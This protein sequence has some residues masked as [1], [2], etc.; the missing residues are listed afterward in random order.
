MHYLQG[1]KST[2]IVK[3]LY[4]AYEMNY[5]HMFMLHQ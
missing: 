3:V 1:R 2:L 5:I 4:K